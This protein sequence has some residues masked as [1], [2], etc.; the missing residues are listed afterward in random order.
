MLKPGQPVLRTLGC[1]RID[2]NR[3]VAVWLSAGTKPPR[4]PQPS[5]TTVAGGA[6]SQDRTLGHIAASQC[7]LE[8]TAASVT[9][10]TDRAHTPDA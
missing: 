2:S 9:H 10:R 3:V 1:G 7:S 8:V 4:L 6:G 5:S